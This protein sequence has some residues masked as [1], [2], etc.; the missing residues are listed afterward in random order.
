[1]VWNKFRSM[2]EIALRWMPQNAFN[3]KSA[4]VQ[5]MA[6]SHHLS[7]YG[8]RYMLPYGF[9]MPQ[10]VNYF[11]N[12]RLWVSIYGQVIDKLQPVWAYCSLLNI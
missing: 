10:K 3:D 1:M 7:Q 6:T 5:I 8:P 4:L 9:T 2:C 12:M 11:R